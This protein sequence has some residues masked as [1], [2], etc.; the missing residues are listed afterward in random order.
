MR[1]NHEAACVHVHG[2][3]AYM[4]HKNV[5]RHVVLCYLSTGPPRTAG[6]MGPVPRPQLRLQLAGGWREMTC[7]PDD[8]EIGG[9]VFHIQF[10]VVY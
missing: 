3:H 9:L 5:C 8:L 4:T 2:M 1:K 6:G 7:I 10:S